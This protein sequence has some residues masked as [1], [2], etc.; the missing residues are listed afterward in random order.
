MMAVK[1]YCGEYGLEDQFDHP[2]RAGL[3]R[4]PLAIANRGP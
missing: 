4:E 1:K 2:S 3:L